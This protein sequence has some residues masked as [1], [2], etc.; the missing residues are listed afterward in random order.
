LGAIA[1]RASGGI[2]INYCLPLGGLP[3]NRPG[4]GRPLFICAPRM[5]SRPLTVLWLREP[6]IDRLADEVNLVSQRRKE[7]NEQSQASFD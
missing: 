1:D 6:Q 4:V 5:T 7:P 3:G 2:H